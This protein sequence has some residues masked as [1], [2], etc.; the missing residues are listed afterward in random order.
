MGGGMMGGGTMGGGMGAYLAL[1]GLLAIVLIVLGV[2][3]VF[4]LVRSMVD[5]GG[6]GG[7]GAEVARQRLDERYA[8]G[9]LS[10]EE[11]LQCRDDL[12]GA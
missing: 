2:A 6:H 5:G 12:A 9:N 1:W 7:T 10:R 11:Y 4:W 3:A 8:S